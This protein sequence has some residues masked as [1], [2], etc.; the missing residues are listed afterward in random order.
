MIGET[1]A[2]IPVEL[3]SGS[4][5]LPAA[6]GV[7]E[8]AWA[9]LAI[10][11]GAG[12]GKDHPFLVGFAAAIREAGIATVRFDFPYLAA[13]RKLPGPAAHAVTAWR[14]VVD[15]AAGLPGPLWAAGKS[16]GGRM[17]SVAAAEG[18]FDVAGLVYLAYPLHP[19]GRPEKPRADHLP[20]IGHPQLFV[21]GENDP[22]IQPREQFD[23]AV[24]SCQDASVTWVPGAVH[25]FE[26]KGSR[27]PADEIGAALADPVV[28]FIRAR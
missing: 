22:F 11:H 5:D 12:A 3:P 8:D 15:F 9:T 10:A 16:Y 2:T 6:V 28:A 25:G 7:P 14:A 24:A 4:V 21:S 13:G 26:V 27:R 1:P 23:E 19:P 20:A 17:A 18:G